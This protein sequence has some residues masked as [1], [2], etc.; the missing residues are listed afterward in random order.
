MTSAGWPFFS[1]PPCWYDC[2]CMC[3]CVCMAVYVW[4][5]VCMWCW[6]LNLRALSKQVFYH[7]HS[8]SLKSHLDLVFFHFLLALLSCHYRFHITVN[9]C[10]F[11][12]SK[13]NLIFFSSS[14]SI[15]HNS[16]RHG[17]RA[18]YR[19]LHPTSM[20]SVTLHMLP[21]DCWPS[22]LTEV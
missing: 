8:L 4:L 10:C 21:K 12:P 14:E 11:A 15:W 9:S 3:D 16:I 2:V 19:Q 13:I 6:A 18:A 7:R 22:E 1:K 17:I 20:P 5:W